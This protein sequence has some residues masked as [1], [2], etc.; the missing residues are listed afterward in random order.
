MI[1]IEAWTDRVG[2][3]YAR[4]RNRKWAEKFVAV[5]VA[6]GGSNNK[7]V[8]FQEGDAAQWF[9]EELSQRQRNDLERFGTISF[10]A[11]P[12]EVGHWYGYDAHTAAE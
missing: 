11:D 10:L 2:N 9:I 3:V 5:V 7:T 4:P 8:F 6:N 1:K 12:W